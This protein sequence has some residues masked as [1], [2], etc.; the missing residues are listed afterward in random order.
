MNLNGQTMMSFL[1]RAHKNG[2]MGTLGVSL[3][4]RYRIM[5]G[6]MGAPGSL[7]LIA[8]LGPIIS[9]EAMLCAWAIHGTDW[10][11]ILWQISYS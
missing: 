7:E 1:S 2:D 9:T 6:R 3:Y 10:L 11:V 8:K 4:Q 5:A